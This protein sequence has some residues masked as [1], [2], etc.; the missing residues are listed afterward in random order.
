LYEGRVIILRYKRSEMIFERFFFFLRE[1]CFNFYIMSI[2]IIIIIIKKKKKKK[3]K[4]T[5]KPGNLYFVKEV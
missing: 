1:S 4:Q 5:N 3:K 2:E